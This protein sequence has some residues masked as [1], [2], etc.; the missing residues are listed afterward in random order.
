MQA[1]LNGIPSPEISLI[2]NFM[3]ESVEPWCAVCQD[4]STWLPR[5]HFYA[6]TMVVK[7]S[8][9]GAGND[10]QVVWFTDGMCL[11]LFGASV[12][13]EGVECQNIFFDLKVFIKE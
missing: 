12:Y 8:R 9:I 11:F 3:L 1:S 13:G 10:C 6:D 4:L 7:G 2:V 5:F